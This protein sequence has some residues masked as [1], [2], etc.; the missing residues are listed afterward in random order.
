[1]KPY[2]LPILLAS[3]IAFPAHAWTTESLTITGGSM[4]THDG[5]SS[6][7]TVPILPGPSGTLDD[8][9]VDGA[10]D[11]D[12]V[13]GSAANP[14]TTFMFLGIPWTTFFAPSQQTP[15]TCNPDC[16]LTI[17]DPEPGPVTVNGTAWDPVITADFSGFFTE[18][19][20]NVFRQGGYATGTGN[21]IVQPTPEAGSGLYSFTLQWSAYHDFGP[22][23]GFTSDWVLT[24][25]AVAVVP[26]PETYTMLLAGLGLVGIAGCRRV[27][28][29]S[30][31][32]S[33]RG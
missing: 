28:G 22:F 20:G 8:G 18:W 3:L 13:H 26:E 25:T 27:R 12:G 9:V 1:M 7:G 17:A 5:T 30:A 14:V 33:A 29:A 24:G 11:A 23:Q 32:P 16:M 31:I 10:V 2:H 19:N 6:F 15:W 21:W 4:T